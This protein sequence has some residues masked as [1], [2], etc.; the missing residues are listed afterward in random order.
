MS[1]KEDDLFADSD[2][3]DDEEIASPAKKQAPK[4]AVAPAADD[5]D[6]D[7]FADSDDDD[8]DVAPPPKKPAAA[9]SKPMSKRERLEALA[10]KK[11]ADTAPAAGEGNGKKSSSS[12]NKEGGYESEDSYDSVTFQRT[13]ADDDFIDTTG[14]DEDAVKE[15]YAEQQF[16]DV[17]GMDEPKKAKKRKYGGGGG[18]RRPRDILEAEE[19]NEE[20]VPTNPIMA[21]VH[22]MKKAKRA[23]RSLDE[24]EE[25]IR[26]FLGSMDAACQQDEQAVAERKPALA[27]LKLLGKVEEMLCNKEIQRNLLDL[28][29]LSYCKRWIQPLPNG[30]L[31]NVTVR[32]RVL[33][34]ISNMNSGSDNGIT[35]PDLKRSEFGRVVMVL[36]KHPDETPAVKKMCK[37]LI[38]QWSRPIFQKSGNMKDLERVSREGSGL[39]AIRRQQA[40]QEQMQ[41]RQNQKS[42]SKH[43]NLQSLIASGK[44]GG[45]DGP[46]SANRVRVPFSKGFAF[47]VRPSARADVP[48]KAQQRGGGPAK[49][50]RGKLSKRM[51]EKS[52]AVTKN[53]RSAN[54]SIEGR[55]TKG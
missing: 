39:A 31:G 17:R 9:A 40:T 28:D 44:K 48:D 6:D 46:A 38:E 11:R 36:W 18:E 49:D 12:N 15:L 22:R 55:A 14:E 7:L 2:D 19:V 26:S 35:P 21:A 41:A 52:R 50:G 29:V 1:D 27:K 25:E 53:Q 4:K 16:E 34:A 43:A 5:D 13:Q 20:G 37:T 47:S 23:K 30:K 42:S 24:I 45:P 51:V 10:R 33:A 8:S 3:S 32:Q 54:I